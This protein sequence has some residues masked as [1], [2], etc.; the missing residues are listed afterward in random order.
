MGQYCFGHHHLKYEGIGIMDWP[1]C[2]DYAVQNE[3][4]RTEFGLQTFRAD[5][6]AMVDGKG[7]VRFNANYGENPLPYWATMLEDE[8]RQQLALDDMAD[9]QGLQFQVKTLGGAGS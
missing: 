7:F 4:G 8:V 1:K 9:P 5:G 3:F 6:R 2:R